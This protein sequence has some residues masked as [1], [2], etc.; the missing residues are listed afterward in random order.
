MKR[1]LSSAL[2]LILVLLASAW[3]AGND[4]GTKVKIRRDEV[5]LFPNPTSSG[6]ITVQSNSEAPLYFYV[7]DQEGTML[8]RM[9]LKGREKRTIRDLK[10]GTYQYDVFRETESIGQGKIIVN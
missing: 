2:F 1:K 6:K 10:K 5:R 7:F 3:G 8:H 4:P 9:V